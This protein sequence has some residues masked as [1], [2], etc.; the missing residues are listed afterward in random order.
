M[1]KIISF[2]CCSLYPIMSVIWAFICPICSIFNKRI[3]SFVLFWV[4]LK[5]KIVFQFTDARNASR[6]FM[7]MFHLFAPFGA[8]YVT[9]CHYC[10]NT[11]HFSVST[12]PTSAHASPCLSPRHSFTT[13]TGDRHYTESNS[14]NN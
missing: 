2:R 12:Q 4:D 8:L 5:H 14:H 6:N 3:T 1:W 9:V 13:F 10:S 7:D 11:T